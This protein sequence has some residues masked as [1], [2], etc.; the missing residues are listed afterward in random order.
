MSK[1]TFTK[2][3]PILLAPLIAP[4]VVLSAIAGNAQPSQTNAV[5]APYQIP[6]GGF[7][8]GDLSGWQSYG[9][10]KN[11]SGMQAFDESLVHNGTYFDNHPYN[12]DGNYQLGITSGSISWDQS[13]ERMGYLRSTDFILGGSGW[14]SFKL[15]GGKYSEFAYVSIRETGTNIEVA[16]FGNRWFDDK[17]RASV[18]YG[19]SISNAEAFLFPYYFD[20]ST[21]SDLGDSLYILLC[22]TSAYDWSILSADSFIT[23]YA[24]APSPS[25]DELAENIL[26]AVLGVGLAVNSIPNG[27]F[28]TN[29][30]GWQ[31]SRAGW[32]YYGD[33]HMR[34]NITGGDGAMGILRSSA[35][36]T[37]GNKYV[38][39]DWAGGMKYDKQ[40]FVSVKE[41]DTNIEVLRFVRRENLSGHEGEGFDNHMLNLSSLDTA[42]EYYLEFADARTGGWGISYV[43]SVRLVPESEWNEIVSTDRAVSISGIATAFG[44]NAQQE[45]LSFAQYFLEQTGPICEDMSGDFDTL[46]PA[47]AT[48]YGS[49]S[50]DAKNYFT[51]D[52]VDDETLVAARLRYVFII[53]KYTELSKFVVNSEGGVYSGANDVI[54]YSFNDTSKIILVVVTSVMTVSAGLFFLI[55]RRRKSIA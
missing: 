12:R 55:S 10:W 38:R 46:W 6:N 29:Y 2:W 20:L 47:L 4:F 17:T 16:R 31:L 30:D 8:T 43:D 13:S 33:H 27:N 34:S 48:E 14:M 21:V 36:T 9:L 22:D 3:L 52:E 24:S 7:E 26:P 53:G 19:D 39:F 45:A 32:G 1:R 15:G 44:L 41:V 49:L 50:N 51:D 37:N 28:D 35:F 18:V 42:K 23:Y 11:E 54:G 5:Y 40:I 25:A